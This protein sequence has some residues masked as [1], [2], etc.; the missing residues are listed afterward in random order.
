MVLM[1]SSAISANCGFD[2]FEPL[3]AEQRIGDPPAIMELADQI[4]GRHRDVVEEHLAEFVVAGDGLDRPDPDAGAAQV[5]QEKAD[6][7]LPRLR[8]ADRCAPARTSSRNDA[9]RWSRSSAPARRICRP[10]AVAR[11]ERLAR[12]EPA[13]GSE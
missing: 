13:P 3:V 5:D 2:V 12:S 1:R 10:R 8:L 4:L 7:G 11:V 9:P 6:A